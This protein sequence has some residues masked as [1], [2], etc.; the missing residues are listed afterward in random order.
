MWKA[1]DAY[2]L[3]VFPRFWIRKVSAK[4][5]MYKFNETL[6]LTKI[7]I[8][9]MSNALFRITKLLTAF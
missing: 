1:R 7:L 2:Y 8:S 5:E 3:V 6:H 9:L 4:G